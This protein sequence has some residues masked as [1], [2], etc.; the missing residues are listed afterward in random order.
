MAKRVCE[1]SCSYFMRDP[2]VRREAEALA[3]AGWEVD[4]I[5]LRALGEPARSEL[6]S[7]IHIQRVPL[8]HKRGR[9]LRY[10]LEY[11]AFF[12]LA[13]ARLSIQQLRRRYDLIHIHTMPNALVFAAWLPKLTGTPIL[14]DTHDPMPEIYQVRFGIPPTHWLNRM[15]LWEERVSFAF[16]DHLLTTNAR[17]P[18]LYVRSAPPTKIS[19]VMN[20]PDPK[21]FKTMNPLERAQP[22]RFTLVYT[23]TV[24]LIYGLDIVIQAVAQLRETIPNICL[25]IVGEGDDLERLQELAARL[26]LGA[27]I[28]FLPPVALDQIPA[29]VS[30][31]DIAV[32]THRKDA[33]TA[34]GFSTKLAEALLLGV[35]VIASRSEAIG[36]YFDDTMV[37]YLDVG[38]AAEFAARVMSLYREPAR[39]AQMVRQARAFFAEH[40]W[41]QERARFFEVVQEMARVSGRGLVSVTEP[42]K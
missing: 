9:K 17:M 41:E 19:I 36:Y 34:W 12:L 28:E 22:R 13:S 14:L 7:S 10:V 27:H 23:G 6:G 8:Q 25:R 20:V 3:D 11:A 24:T 15:L 35:P 40:S 37:D 4:V 21:I 38:D 16:A 39:G 33:V 18:L 2:R 32:A 31:A 26:Q 29:L 5:C 30:S 42:T 1:I